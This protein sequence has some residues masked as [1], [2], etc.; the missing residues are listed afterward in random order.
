MKIRK[1]SVS[2]GVAI[3]ALVVAMSG[4]AFAATM[5]TTKQIKDGTILPRDLNVKT[6]T[7]L[8]GQR[9]PKG[10]TGASGVNGTNG[11]NGSSGVVS[12]KTV[13]A[14]VASTALTSTAQYLGQTTSVTVAAGEKVVG[15][16][17]ASLASSASS[18]LSLA[19][20]YDSGGALSRFVGIS[21]F[22]IYSVDAT[23]R[24]YTA[25]NATTLSPGTYTVGLCGSGTGTL[26]SNDWAIGWFM[27][28]SSS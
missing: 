6:R 5:I 14:P 7:Y 3:I 10:A 15:S 4:T 19:L 21:T 26:D 28:A 11:I 20:C 27:V 23:R 12:I 25:T 18:T 22:S 24:S 9:G 8:K 2:F 1:P 16:V 17:A 13:G